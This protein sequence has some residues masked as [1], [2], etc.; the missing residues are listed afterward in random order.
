MFLFVS[1]TFIQSQENLLKNAG[2]ENTDLKFFTFNGAT[3][4][5][6]KVTGWDLSD[7]PYTPDDYNNIG[8]NKYVIRGMIEK[9]NPERNDNKQYLRIQQYEWFGDSKHGGKE[10][11]IAEGGIQQTVKVKPSTTYTLTFMYR[12]SKHVEKDRIVP[13]YYS[14]QEDD[15]AP[16]KKLFYNELDENWY[17]GKKTFTTSPTAKQVR[18]RF[19]I[20]ATRI[21]NWG[22]N[23]LQWADFDD[24]KLVEA[25]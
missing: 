14:I 1:T 18:V 13:A 16:E 7:K 17:E 12:L 20:S 11:A 25:K 24:V 3:N 6:D 10:N 23:R 5:P 21:Y 19:Y 8:L 15:K 22:G 4:C 2:F 9:H